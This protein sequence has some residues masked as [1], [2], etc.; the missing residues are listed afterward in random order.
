MLLSH[1]HLSHFVAAL[2]DLS[3]LKFGTSGANVLNKLKIILS[4]QGHHTGM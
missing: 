2:K 4:E 1:V 3:L